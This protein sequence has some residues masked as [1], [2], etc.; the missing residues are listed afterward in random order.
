[1]ATTSMRKIIAALLAALLASPPAFAQAPQLGAGQVMGNSTA[2]Q[3]PARAENVTSIFDRAFGTAA[4]S[5]LRRGIGGWQAEP[6]LGWYI[7]GSADYP[8]IQSAIT[9]ASAAGSGVVWVPCG[10]YTIGTAA[11]PATGI[12]ATNTKNVSVVG[13]TGRN[14]GAAQCTIVTYAGTG[15]AVTYG[16]SIGF[17][18]K[19]L[20]LRG[21]TAAKLF[22]G[23]T[24][25][26]ISTSYT[27]IS[28]NFFQGQ[29]GVTIILDM[30]SS[31]GLTVTRNAFTG[32]SIGIR[33]ITSGGGIPAGQY[34]VKTL[35]DDNAFQPSLSTSAIQGLETATVSNNIFQGQLTAYTSG[36]A[37]TC[38]RVEWTGN[39]H[40]DATT[41]QPLIV[42]NCNYWL[43]AS[44]DYN[45]GGAAAITQANTTGT[46]KSGSDKFLGSSPWIDIGTGNFLELGGLSPAG[47]AASVSG[48]ATYSAVPVSIFMGSV[49]FGATTSPGVPVSIRSQGSGISPRALQIEASDF[50]TNGGMI[51]INKDPGASGAARIFSGGTATVDG[52]TIDSG[53]LTLGLAGTSLGR[54]DILGSTSGNVS[55]RPQAAAGTYNFNLPTTAGSVGQPL[56][57]GGGGA[58]AQTYG[59]LGRTA[60]GTGGIVG[61]FLRINTQ[62]FC[63]SGCSTTIAGGGSGTYTPT[64]GMLYATIECVGGGGGGGG[65]TGAASQIYGG[66]GGGSGSYCQS[67]SSAASIGASQTVTIGAGGAGGTG[68]AN[69]STGGASSVGALCTTNG[70]LG[71]QFSAT[72]LQLGIGGAG[73]AVG[74]GNQSHPGNAGSGGSFNA[75]ASNIQ[76]PSG[77]GGAS[78]FGGAPVSAIPGAN[79]NGVAGQRGAGGSGAYSASSATTPTGGAGGA[80]YC[81]VTEWLNQ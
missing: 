17:E 28:D 21:L 38:H 41:P 32:G 64:T 48:T 4:G 11:N 31:Q 74:T 25:A 73:G 55:I 43:S 9:A 57:S 42:S 44:N 19:N 26:A 34:A 33:G 71:G 39:W 51:R 61:A 77:V 54:L 69:G 18:W 70:G 66:G 7:V 46:I 12:N 36:P 45:A 56:L 53:L 13:Q 49:A 37:T 47:G 72:G 30:A 67:S 81:V 20:Y 14:G 50:G 2:S 23:T 22:D 10:N 75:T 40:G 65:V 62:T 29:N 24:G 6:A 35:I 27:V 58:T 8:T 80:G 1:M 59:T 3:R 5:V 16:G 15:T 76:I 79:Q 52:I 63:P 68:S 60:G 78:F